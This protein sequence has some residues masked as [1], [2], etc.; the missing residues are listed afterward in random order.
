MKTCEL[1]S[2]SIGAAVEA[3]AKAAS[4]FLETVRNEEHRKELKQVTDTYVRDFEK[5]IKEQV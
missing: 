2:Q 5:N 1:R 4:Q 3:M